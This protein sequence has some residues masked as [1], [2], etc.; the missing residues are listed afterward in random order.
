MIADGVLA[1]Y[2]AHPERTVEE[3]RIGGHRSVVDM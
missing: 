3:T 2:E 1:D